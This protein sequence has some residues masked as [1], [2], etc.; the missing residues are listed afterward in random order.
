MF[1]IFHFGVI[2]QQ[3]QAFQSV[4]VQQILMLNM[5]FIWAVSSKFECEKLILWAWEETIWVSNEPEQWSRQAL[6]LW[7]QAC[8]SNIIRLAA[9]RSSH[10]SCASDDL[11]RFYYCAP[12]TEVTC[13]CHDLC[14]SALLVERKTFPWS[15]DWNLS[16]CKWP[17][18]TYVSAAGGSIRAVMFSADR[19]MANCWLRNQM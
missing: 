16:R 6:W 2:N 11:I 4:A 9:T 10:K 13:H 3:Q 1:G 15:E 5:A 17:L 7:T 19:A 14:I 12:C 8:A 18:V